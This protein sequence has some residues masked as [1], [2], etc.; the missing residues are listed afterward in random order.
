MKVQEINVKEKQKSNL[1]SE[2]TDCEI[3]FIL[4]AVAIWFSP[5]NDIA[6]EKF[7]GRI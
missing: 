1:L 5:E 2:K 4:H 3:N 6:K 7:K